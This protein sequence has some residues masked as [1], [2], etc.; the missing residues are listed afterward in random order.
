MEEWH[1]IPSYPDYEASTEGRIRRACAKQ[2][3]RI[4]RELRQSRDSNGYG[5]VGM[6]RDGK[7]LSVHAHRLIAETFHG[8]SPFEG[9]VVA[10]NDGAR[11]NN[12]PDNLRWATCSENHADKDRHGTNYNGQAHH[13]SSLTSDNIRQIRSLRAE[14]VGL[15]ELSD[16]FGVSTQNISMI[17]RRLAWKH[18]V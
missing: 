4:G 10:H 6:Y 9:A 14:G 16:R 5:V 3:W 11:L 1:R 2:L 15:A 17:A 18:V 12:R 8:L 13:A 7:S